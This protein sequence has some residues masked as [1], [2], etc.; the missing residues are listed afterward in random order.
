[1]SRVSLD[2]GGNEAITRG[3]NA[4]MRQTLADNTT[5]LKFTGQNLKLVDFSDRATIE[6]FLDVIG[7]F[8]YEKFFLSKEGIIFEDSFW[9][10]G[11]SRVGR[12]QWMRY[13]ISSKKM[14]FSGNLW[15]SW[16]NGL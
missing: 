14:V 7:G 11:R 5:F 16:A 2:P 6:R 13:W 8:T 9:G 3:K 10:R 15:E 4:T 12:V 1:M